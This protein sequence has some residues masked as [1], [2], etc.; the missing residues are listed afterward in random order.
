VVNLIKRQLDGQDTHWTL[1]SEQYTGEDPVSYR[2]DRKIR[3]TE[4]NK[5][6]EKLLE[7]EI[8]QK[9]GVTR[10]YRSP[11]EEFRG[12]MVRSLR[13]Y[14]MGHVFQENGMISLMEQV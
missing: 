4:G 6:E 10:D 9:I 1:S 3:I 12:V 7:K 11:A 13:V 14:Y 2:M 5:N 8:R